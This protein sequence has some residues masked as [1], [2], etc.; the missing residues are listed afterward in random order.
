MADFELSKDYYAP[1][2]EHIE[3]KTENQRKVISTLLSVNPETF[4]K[5]LDKIDMIYGSFS[6]YLT[7]CIGMTPEKR[8][9]LCDRYLE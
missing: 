2:L 3:V 7:E 6:N 9:I 8:A 1:D 5:T 4:Q